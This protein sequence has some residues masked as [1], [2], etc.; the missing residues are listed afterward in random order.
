M[1]HL[2]QL[3]DR[4]R[5]SRYVQKE[6]AGCWHWLGAK[7]PQGHGVFRYRGTTIPAHRFSLLMLGTELAGRMAWRCSTI[8]CV[9]PQ[10]VYTRTP[11]AELLERRSVSAS[12]CWEWPGSTI[13]NGYGTVAF[14]RRAYLLHRL[15]Y[16]IFVNPVPRGQCVLHRCDNKLCY[17]P[18]HLFLGTKA[19]NNADRHAK[20]RTAC[21][22]TIARHMRGR[23]NV[24]AKLTDDDVR[25]IRTLCSNG[26]SQSAV[27]A[28]FSID[29]SEISRI[30]SRER[31]AHVE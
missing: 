9:N 13:T 16:E 29:R 8:G 24:G 10:H 12:G 15:S 14:G 17:N 28:Q 22:E 1:T 25:R 19:E 3:Q 11:R 5:F 23:L 7:T 18:E 4:E 27:A 6:A 30:V 26:T 21:G 2:P 31:W 20:G